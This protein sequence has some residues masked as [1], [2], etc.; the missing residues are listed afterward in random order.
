M[1]HLSFGLEDQVVIVTGGAGA[2]GVAICAGF[3]E[4]GARVAVVDL[5]EA[6]AQAIADALPGRHIGLGCDLRNVAT[7]GDLIAR[8]EQ[9]LGPADHLVN[10]AGVIKRTDDL[11]AVT[12]ADWDLQHDVNIKALFFVSQA[13]ARRLVEDGRDGSIVNYTSQGWMSGGFGGSVVY[14]AAKGAVTTLTRGMARSWAPHGIRVNA[15]A[16]GLVET[17]MLV[18]PDTTEEDLDALRASIPLKRLGQPEDHVGTTVFLTSRMAHYMTGA[19]VNVSGGF[20]M[21]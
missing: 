17:P 15:V 3:A 8:V 16:P 18:T 2:I 12:E 21:Y 11:F 4:A 9:G 7:M 13:F 14:N 5:D 20:L 10:I 19:T 1:Q 6:T